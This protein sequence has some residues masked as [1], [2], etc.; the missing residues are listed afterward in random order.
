MSSTRAETFVDLGSDY[1]S[2]AGIYDSAGINY[3]LTFIYLLL[4]VSS[5]SCY[6]P[7]SL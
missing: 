5:L 7:A 4:A 3:F 1:C 6:V 2:I